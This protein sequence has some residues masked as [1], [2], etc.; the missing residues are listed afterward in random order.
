MPQLIQFHLPNFFSDFWLWQSFGCLADP[1]VSADARDAKQ[2]SQPA[3]TGFAEAVKQDSQGLGSFRA[4]TFRG[5]GKITTAGFT[6]VT[7]QP[8]YKPFLINEVLPQF[9]QEISMGYLLDDFQEA[10]YHK[11]ILS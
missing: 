2:F 3:K 5:G 6:A 9:L 11:S 4:A 8:A 7:L 1:L 10:L